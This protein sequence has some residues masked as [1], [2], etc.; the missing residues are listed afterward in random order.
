MEEELIGDGKKRRRGKV[1]KGG[2]RSRE[3]RS[4]LR[5]RNGLWKERCGA[6]SHKL[7]R[8]NE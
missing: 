2:E 8:M 6:D 5:K 1:E 7:E 4:R 3:N